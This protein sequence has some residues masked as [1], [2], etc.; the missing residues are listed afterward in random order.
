MGL[1]GLIQP[2]SHCP[3]HKRCVGR[4]AGGAEWVGVPGALRSRSSWVKLMDDAEEP[5]HPGCRWMPPTQSRLTRPQ[6]PQVQGWRGFCL[7]LFA[8]QRSPASE[9]TSCVSDGLHSVHPHTLSSPCA[10]SYSRGGKVNP[11]NH[12]PPRPCRH[13]QIAGLQVKELQLSPAQPC[14]LPDWVQQSFPWI[15][16]LPNLHPSSDLH[17]SLASIPLLSSTLPVTSNLL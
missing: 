2:V 4:V 12:V 8:S 9:H 3:W 13:L 7:I 6:P 14:C 15:P 1:W 17:P 16:S 11:V 5:S 10:V